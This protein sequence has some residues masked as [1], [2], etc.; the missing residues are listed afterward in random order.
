MKT[1]TLAALALLAAAGGAG[2]A[3]GG[4]AVCDAAAT[5][6]SDSGKRS[7]GIVSTVHGGFRY[8][9]HAPSGAE[10]LFDLRRDPRCLADVAA[11]NPDVVVECRRQLLASVGASSLDEL[12]APY[13]ETI[14]RLEAMGYF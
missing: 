7:L 10:R 13:A 12:R 11:A 9:F 1:R 14:R 3:L 4:K 8:E 6:A 5:D 2:V